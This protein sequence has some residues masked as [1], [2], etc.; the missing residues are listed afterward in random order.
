[1]TSA[2][3]GY[4][5]ALLHN[6]VF[7]YYRAISLGELGSAFNPGD[8]LLELGCGTGEEAVQLAKKGIRVL[9]TDSSE[10][11]V[12]SARRRIQREGLESLLTAR[13]WAIEELDALTREL[14]EGAFDGAFSSFGALNCAP[15]I[16]RLP[17]DLH[18][19]IRPGGRFLCSVMNRTC[20]WELLSGLASLRPGRAFRRIG[21]PAAAIEGVP[22][23]QR[24]VRYFTPVEMED[25]FRPMFQIEGLR[26]HP[27]LPPPY[28]DGVFRRLPGYLKWAARK[29]D[30]ALRGL[31]DHLFIRMKRRAILQ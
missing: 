14:G 22:D 10:S 5:S 28:L 26:D 1:M 24:R 15:G 13:V 11:Q 29:D 25:M 12:E 3:C 8:R 17:K 4:D 20:A 16:E 27:L 19:L 31:G 30:G 18:T 2:S 23:S 21:A 9:L 6:R 7:A